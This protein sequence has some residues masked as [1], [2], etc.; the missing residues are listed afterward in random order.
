LFEKIK[1]K[2]KKKPKPIKKVPLTMGIMFMLLGA[3]FLVLVF[4][5]SDPVTKSAYAVVAVALLASGTSYLDKS[6]VLDR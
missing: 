6:G 5:S 4:T 1:K 2:T 3:I